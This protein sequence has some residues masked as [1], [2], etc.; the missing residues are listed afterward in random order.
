VAT[1]TVEPGLKKR[2]ELFADKKPDG[3][4]A[5]GEDLSGGDGVLPLK[6]PGAE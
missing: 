6:L 2:P 5:G 3:A 4:P 1:W